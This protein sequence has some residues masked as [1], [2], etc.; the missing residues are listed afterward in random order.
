MGVALS[1]ACGDLPCE[2]VRRDSS[3]FQVP[4]WSEGARSADFDT[5][6]VIRQRESFRVDYCAL[7]HPQL[8]LLEACALQVGF[9]SIAIQRGRAGSDSPRN[10]LSVSPKLVRYRQLDR[11]A[12]EILPSL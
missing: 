9:Y 3:A 2:F 5:V 11:T 12:C 7:G 10:R 1:L 4:L 6:K 8:R